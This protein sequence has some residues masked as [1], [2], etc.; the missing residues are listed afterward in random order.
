MSSFA[1]QARFH[2]LEARV[3]TLEQKLAEYEH[4][5]PQSQEVS[6][7]TINVIPTKRGP[8]RPRKEEK[9]LA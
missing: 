5:I 9:E 3:T 2:A 8:G 6:A 7:E 4:R 1:D